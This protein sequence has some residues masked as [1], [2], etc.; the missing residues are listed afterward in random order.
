MGRW[1]LCWARRHAPRSC[2]CLAWRRH[3]TCVCARWCGGAIG[4][5]LVDCARD[6][7]RHYPGVRPPP[8]LQPLRP[9]L[10]LV[11]MCFPSSF[12]I[13]P[14][15]LIIS[16]VLLVFATAAVL[17]LVLCVGTAA[18]DCT[19]CCCVRCW[20]CCNTPLSVWCA[21]RLACAPSLQHTAACQWCG[22]AT[23]ASSRTLRQC[24]RSVCPRATSSA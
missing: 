12:C 7:Q 21:C 11:A 18:A 2:G 5:P 19:R 20:R 22:T 13:L 23:Q 9:V 8:M 6:V 1:V 15:R 10:F 17:A 4:A 14:R 3:T 24:T 16:L